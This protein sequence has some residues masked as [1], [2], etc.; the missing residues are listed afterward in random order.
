MEGVDL[1]GQKYVIDNK[2]GGH[3]GRPPRGD[4]MCARGSPPN[5][6]AETPYDGHRAPEEA[7][8]PKV[9]VHR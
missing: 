3:T 6:S 2:V 5:I 1:E 7:E 4:S 9:V 8:Q